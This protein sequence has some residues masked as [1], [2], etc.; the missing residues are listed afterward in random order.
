M[1][2]T[3][4]TTAWGTTVVRVLRGFGVNYRNFRC[5]AMQCCPGQDFF[6][7]FV[8]CLFSSCVLATR[9][10]F[11]RT[12][13]RLSYSF[14]FCRAPEC[15]VAKAVFV[16]IH[17]KSNPSPYWTLSYPTNKETPPVFIGSISYFIS[18]ILHK[19]IIPV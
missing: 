18:F 10:D 9:L 4:E 11:K 1:A 8:Y 15:A 6:R 2:R 19:K 12:L 5:A 3:F 13:K 17:Y 7:F 16:K 14:F